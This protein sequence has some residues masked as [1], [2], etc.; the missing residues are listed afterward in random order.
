MLLTS[1]PT[2]WKKEK[3]GRGGKTGEERLCPMDAA[4]A[5]GA[6]RVLGL[7]PHTGWVQIPWRQDGL[8]RAEVPPERSSSPGGDKGQ[9]YVKPERG[10]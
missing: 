10:D 3:K 9:C 8:E 7:P 5:P 1:T 4:E 6:G 2:A